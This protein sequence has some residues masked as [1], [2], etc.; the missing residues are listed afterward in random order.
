MTLISLTTMSKSPWGYGNRGIVYHFAPSIDNSLRR[1]RAPNRGACKRPG[2]SGIFPLRIRLHGQARQSTLGLHSASVQ[3]QMPHLNPALPPTAPDI[4]LRGPGVDHSAST[5]SY[6]NTQPLVYIHHSTCT[7]AVGRHTGCLS[8]RDYSQASIYHR[9]ARRQRRQQV[10][11]L[12][13]RRSGLPG[14]T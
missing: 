4:T 13:K 8:Q 7:I 3:Y 6:R 14:R 1:Y 11:Q 9:A 10:H 2:L 12:E 5:P